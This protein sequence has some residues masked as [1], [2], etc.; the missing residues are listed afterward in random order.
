MFVFYIS[1]DGIFQNFVDI[2]CSTVKPLI[3]P[4]VVCVNMKVGRQE[5]NRGLIVLTEH[6]SGISYVHKNL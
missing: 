1:L 5:S 6:K 2:L 3:V 4:Q